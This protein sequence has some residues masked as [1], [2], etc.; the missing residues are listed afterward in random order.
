MSPRVMYPA[1]L[2]NAETFVGTVG[3]VNVTAPVCPLTDVTGAVYVSGRAPTSDASKTTV[4][5]CPFTLMT[6]PVPS[7]PFVTVKVVVVLSVNVIV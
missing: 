5:L 4:P 6:A 7:L 2:L 1:S 3:I